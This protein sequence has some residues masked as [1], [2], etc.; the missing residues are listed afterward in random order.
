LTDSSFTQ[1]MM[2]ETIKDVIDE[3]T[4]KEIAKNHF[5]LKI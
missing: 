1:Y 2:G 3:K 4:F 5:S